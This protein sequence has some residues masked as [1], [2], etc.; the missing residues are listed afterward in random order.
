MT[1]SHFSGPVYS[2]NGFYTSD[3]SALT[4]SQGSDAANLLPG[5]AVRIVA[6]E[7]P[8]DKIDL[9]TPTWSSIVANGTITYDTTVANNARKA[10][11]TATANT[12]R[13]CLATTINCVSGQKYFLRCKVENMVGTPSTI[14][15]T[16]SGGILVATINSNGVVGIVWTASAT[17]A[18]TMRVGLNPGGAAGNAGDSVTISEVSWGKLTST[19]TAPREYVPPSNSISFNY[20]ASNTISSGRVTDVIGVV[21]INSKS[22]SVFVSGDSLTNNSLDFPE[23]LRGLRP[24]IGVVVNG[25]PGA[26]GATYAPILGPMISAYS[27]IYRVSDAADPTPAA[28]APFNVYGDKPSV[29]LWEYVV[30]DIV[31]GRTL[32][33]LKATALSVI[34]T[35]LSANVRVVLFD[36]TP[37]YGNPST[38]WTFDKELVRQQY[39]LWVSNLSQSQMVRTFSIAKILGSATVYTNFPY[40]TLQSAYDTSG[41]GLHIHPNQTGS[42][43]VAN[44]L[45]AIL[46]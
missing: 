15:W 14:L 35:C 6:N 8:F 44:A 32:D 20:P 41:D 38:I 34:N 4:P 24:D 29:V 17:A 43:A 46:L 45:S 1:A 21:N 13:V 28:V 16:S 7:L 19:E 27:G 26:T 10:T 37:F 40:D 22:R 33:Q 2:A 25:I 30:N 42:T 36:C 11:C 5:G 31:Q 18:E 23:I 12:A 9:Q 3:N 39:N